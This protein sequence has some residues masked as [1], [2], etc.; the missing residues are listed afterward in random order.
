MIGKVPA[1]VYKKK[2]GKRVDVDFFALDIG[3]NLFYLEGSPNVPVEYRALE[4]N[5]WKSN[6]IGMHFAP[7]RIGLTRRNHLSLLTSLDIDYIQMNL[8]NSYTFLPRMDSLTLVQE[9]V[10]S[11][12]KN[13]LQA[14]YFQ[15]PLLLSFQSNP[16]KRWKNFKFAV[17]AY[18]GFLMGS[19][20]KQ[21]A[22]GTTKSRVRDDFN[23]NRVRYGL[24]T[25]VSVSI[26]ELY[27][28]YNL[29]TMFAENQA[30]EIRP[31]S[32]GIRLIKI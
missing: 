5:T 23:L 16:Q 24:T 17:G 1:G 26:V 14:N 27:A 9:N 32:I 21:K 2:K 10:S 15:I 18:G 31:L 7:T 22:R 19:H 30:P 11:Y 3:H 8:Q 12:K 28:N 6:H 13:Q 25:R 20:T 4:T 29:S